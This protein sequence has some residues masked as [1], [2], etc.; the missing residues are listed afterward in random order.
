MIRFRDSSL[1]IQYLFFGQEQ[2]YIVFNDMKYYFRMRM[3]E[4]VRLESLFIL[5]KARYKFLIQWYLPNKEKI[6]PKCILFGRYLIWE[7]LHIAANL[8]DQRKII[9][10]CESNDLKACITP[11]NHKCIIFFIFVLFIVC[12][13]SY[14]SLSW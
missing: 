5:K 10:F 14:K 2:K 11:K 3:S 4:R 7:V 12:T 1:N 6:R 13:C 8:E 9:D